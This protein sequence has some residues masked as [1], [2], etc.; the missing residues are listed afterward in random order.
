MVP[1][2]VTANWCRLVLLYVDDLA[3]VL[4]VAA[5]AIKPRKRV[6]CAC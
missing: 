4:A 5:G 1:A 2:V 6:S 3:N